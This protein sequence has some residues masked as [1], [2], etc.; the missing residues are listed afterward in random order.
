M[1][2]AFVADIHGN[3]PALEAVERDLAS[4]APAQIYCLGDVVGY[5]AEPWECLQHVRERGWGM[6]LGNHEAA[7]IEPAYAEVFNP[8]ARAALLYSMGAIGKEGR[9][10]LRT[11]PQVIET[12]TLQLCHGWSH[13]TR[14]FQYVLSEQDV[15]NIFSESTRPTVVMGH[16]HFHALFCR[17]AGQE[18]S[19]YSRDLVQS[20]PV[21]ARAVI[22]VGSV[23][24]P[25]DN[26]PRACWALYDDSSRC[27][28][29]RRVGYDA[30]EAARRIREAGLSEKLAD[31]LLDGR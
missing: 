27:W 24:Q 17:P 5:G 29:F 11:L 10:W 4:C 18:G 21:G 31:R 22:N 30:A 23:G 28:E 14:R 26:D 8:Y 7:I 25:R 12:E 1:K 13:G 19:T 2:I 15:G 20:V 16:G 6:L 3:L 9:A